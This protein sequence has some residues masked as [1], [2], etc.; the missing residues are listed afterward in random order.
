MSELRALLLTD[1]V[2]STQL[3]QS[4]GDAAASALWLTHD[5]MARDLLYAWRGQEI[6][7]SDGFLLLFDRVADAAA[8]ALAYHRALRT[9]TP[10]LRARAGLHWGAVQLR[11]NGPAYVARGAKPVEVDG[12][13]KALAARLM[14]LALGGQTLL[15]AE[16]VAALEA[17]P[18]RLEPRGHWMLKGLEEPVA[19]FELGDAAAP[20]TPPPDSAKAYRVVRH[21]DC[22][23]PARELPHS[24][25]AERDAF[26]GRSDALQALSAHFDAGVR[27]VTLVGMGGIGKTRLAQRYARLWL[28]NHPGGA[29]FCDLSAADSLGG[30]VTAVARGLNVPLGRAD[31]VQQLGAAIAGRGP[32][33]VLL[34]NFEQIVAHAEATVGAWL[35]RAPQAQFLVT[36]RELLGIVGEQ[37]QVLP[38][39]AADEA[40]A[41]FRHRVHAAGISADYAPD[42]EQ[43]L[44]PLIDLLDRLPLA[45]ELAA[46]RARVLKPRVLLQRM[47][48]RLTLLAARGGR[49]DRQATLRATLDWSWAL[50][51]AVEQS[52]LAQLSVFEGG[53]TLRAAEA[54]VDTSTT[55]LSPAVVN[56][57]QSLV[58]KSLVR[59]TESGR[60]EMLR[61]VQDYAA[62]Q[63]GASAFAD[64]TAVTQAHLRHAEFHAGLHLGIDAA[65]LCAELDNLM[66]AVRRA[67]AAA[68]VPTAIGALRGA[69]AAI[70]LRGPFQAAVELAECVRAAPV[71]LDATAQAC[72]D[73]VAGWGLKATGRVADAEHRLLASL[74]A[75][76]Q[77]GD[78]QGEGNV[79]AMLGD[80]LGYAGRSDEAREV[81]SAG[82]VAARA[83]GDRSLECE[84]LSA[85]GGLCQSLGTLDDA[86]MYHEAARA[87]ARAAGERRWEG[88]SLG[89]LGVVLA[90]QGHNAEAEDSYREALAISRELGDRQWEG[91]TL[92]NLGL[93]H[94]VQGRYD[95][96]AGELRLALRIARDLGHVRLECIVLCNLGIAVE[97]AG[98]PGAAA[99]H[100]DAALQVA[101]SLGDRRSE[102]QILGYRGLLDARQQRFEEAREA[103]DA[104]E[105]LL[106]A[107]GD[108]L[109]L[110][111]LLCGRAECEHL[112]GEPAA[113][114]QLLR[115]ACALGAEVGADAGSELHQAL[116]R[117]QALS[118][119]C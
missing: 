3:S 72:I 29:W 6:D 44:R 105:R 34:D 27:L 19:L 11:H 54:V 96:A 20:F 21:A 118:R 68:Q 102:G 47:G 17:A 119:Q 85:L 100:H 81:L 16:A 57:V 22:W 65:A 46:A 82:L 33:L 40:V 26:I 51:S 36:S 95:D 48:E 24:L 75:A 73:L 109:S 115:R 61:T 117:V 101:R 13:A 107:S 39:L 70:K 114:A 38:P 15:S 97:A 108:R 104:G 87:A 64:D 56:V 80:L 111:M 106:G 23:L 60:L 62:E 63:R 31:P 1:L 8:Y 10:P 93:L 43:A 18:G 32:C 112:A 74:A 2:D 71:E 92:C 110:A 12:L 84:V 116:E 49:P 77:V 103:L 50:L 76:R 25:P 42:D 35:E 83:G 14:A 86:R 98:E 45:I 4:L 78:L 94:H 59:E 5:A 99:E 37:V 53:F 67:S 89:N 113:A 41:M 30:I 66:A 88:G 28:G 9:L 58:E 91:N 69:W 7:K 52:A 79:L 90:N 55:R